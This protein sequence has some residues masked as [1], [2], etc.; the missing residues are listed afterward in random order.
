ML[1]TRFKEIVHSLGWA[2]FLPGL[3]RGCVCMGA[4]GKPLF[5]LAPTFFD[6]TPDFKFLTLGSIE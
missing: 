6:S 1:V 2:K 3:S 5:F 4:E